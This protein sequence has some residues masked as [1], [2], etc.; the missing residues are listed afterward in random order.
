MSNALRMVLATPLPED[1]CVQL[2][3]DVPGLDL[4]RDHSLLPPMRHPG[5]H[6]GDPAFRRTPEQQAAFDALVDSAEALYGI[7]DVS[8]AA[9]ARTV[10]ANPRLRWVQTMAAGGAAQVAAAGLPEGTLDRIAFTTS[11]GVHG[12]TLAE[13]A[14]LGVLAGAK[15][16]PKL[17]E[18]QRA[19]EW[20]PRWAMG[21]VHEQ[22]ILVV[23]LGS[24][25]R[26]C[27]RLFSAVGA[28]VVG[29][30]RSEVDVPGVSRV[31]GLDELPDAVGQVDAIVVTLP[32]APGTNGLVDDAVLGAARPGVTVVNVGRGTVID[33]EALARAL[34]SGQVGFAALDVVA[35]EPLD[36]SSPLWTHPRVLL[37]PHTAA[38]TDAEDAR[39]ARLAADNARRLLAGEPLR[40][41]V[42]PEDLA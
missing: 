33:E 13:F 11:A 5:D 9:L 28:T 37:S 3:R 19:G 6:D 26:D 34:G 38:L 41:R 15:D 10:A 20:A 22:T 42:R 17:Q 35:H 36:R 31:V 32:G 7:P 23:G 27:V 2:E 40:N 18:H 29:A 30:N 14:L 1:L 21:Q 16:L 4:V 24:I 39:I 8:P 12:G 25:G